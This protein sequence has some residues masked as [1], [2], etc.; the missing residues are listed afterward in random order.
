MADLNTTSSTNLNDTKHQTE[1][2]KQIEQIEQKHA[3]LL[4]L[5][6]SMVASRESDTVES[7]LVSSGEANFL[8][9]SKGHEG[10]V[11]LAPYL[12]KADYLHCHY[13]DKALMLARGITSEMFFYSALAKAESHSAGRQMVSHM[14]DKALNILSIVGPVGNNALQ[15]AGIAHTIKTNTNSPIVVCAFGDGTSQQGEVMEAIAEAKRHNL[16]ILFFIHNNDL[17]ISTRTQ[18]QTFFS[19]P[20]GTNATSFYDI[21]IT[22]LDGT[23]PF[24][25]YDA[26]GNLIQDMRHTSNPQIIVFNVNRLD[27]HSNADNQKLYRN[28][29]ELHESLQDDPLTNSAAYLAQ[30]GIPQDIIQNAAKNAINNVRNAIKIARNG[31]MPTACFTAERPLPDTLQ[32]GNSAAIEY[33][34]NMTSIERYTML[35]AMKEVFRYQLNSDPQVCL[36]GEDIE[37]DK[38][39]VFG[40]TRGLSTS[41]PNRVRNTALSESTIVGVAAGMALA[42]KKPVAFIQFADF[43]PLA[44]NQIFSELA[45][46]YWRTNGQWQCPVIIFAACGGYRPGLG[47][48]HSQTNEATYA[49]IPGL[50]VYMPSNA[51]DAAG[52]LNAAFKSNRPSVFLYP[53]KLLNNSSLVDTTSTDIAKHIIPVGR[54]RI[55]KSGSDITLVGF[56]NTIALCHLVADTLDTIGITAEIIDLRT[57]KPYDITTIVASVIKTKHLLVTHEDNLTCGIGG[58]IIATIMEKI[59]NHEHSQSSNTGK[60]DRAAIKVRR[61]TKSDTYTPCNYANQLEV[62]PTYEKI[63]TAAAEM[64]DLEL[65][66]ENKVN[67]DNTAQVVEVIGA[68]PS[69]ESILIAKLNVK[70]GDTV[71]AGD[72]LVEIEA[73]KSAGEILSPCDGIVEEIYVRVDERAVVGHNLLKIRLNPS[74]INSAQNIQQQVQKLTKITHKVRN[75]EPHQIHQ[76]HSVGIHTPHFKMAS[77]HITNEMLLHDLKT[78]ES[79]DYTEDDII[80]RTG[81]TDRYWLAENESIVDLAAMVVRNALDAANLT[82]SNIDL[83]ICSTCSNEKYL[84][85][86]LACLVLEKL[87]HTYGEQTIPAY[88]I[89]AA[90][91]GYIYALQQA[92]DFLQ[93]RPDKRVLIIT[94]EALSKLLDTKDFDTALLFGDA[95]T[96]TIACGN[97]HINEC[98]AQ[99]DHVYLSATGETGEV[100]SVPTSR[101]NGKI[102][103]QGKKLFPIAV[104]SMVVAIHKCCQDFGI[105]FNALD[106]VVSHQANQRILDAVGRQMGFKPESLYTNISRYGNT[107]SCTI[108]TALAETLNTQTSNNKIALCA[109]GG[110]FTSGAALLTIR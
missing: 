42:G 52:L 5:Y 55:A 37:D 12:I 27:N 104:R 28:E 48:F 2:M 16:P 75:N 97:N 85:P 80:K 15:A 108:P 110:G 62:L 79:P 83:V 77:K 36:L 9:S 51:A 18:G 8:A 68:S 106:L 60:Y 94:A 100:L 54:A 93:T 73:S 89:N 29:K 102:S 67:T 50:D 92:K 32:H 43:M 88:D 46:M 14:S 57:I 45:T 101:K 19:L 40:I 58:D 70:I 82:L 81:I 99:I 95:A 87:Y 103:L 91:S 90:C 107:S 86:S 84:S 30:I 109:F 35:E 4:N 1:Q 76:I 3:I 21:P 23:N 59:S 26:V 49:H 38:G 7:E 47:P 56:G 44:Y 17:A 13:R 6:Q 33:R 65:L 25:E 24:K 53:K 10:S 41:F 22:Y 69:D 63:L 71:K 61:V 39:D 98:I 74:S 66:W 11:I 20:N 72:I 78:P 105:D 34:G 31:T 96:A 64:L